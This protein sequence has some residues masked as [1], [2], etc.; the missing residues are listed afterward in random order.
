[1]FKPRVPVS[2]SLN[3]E[4]GGHP[5]VLSVQTPVFCGCRGG[6]S[7]SGVPLTCEASGCSG[8]QCGGWR[9]DFQRETAPRPSFTL[10]SRFPSPCSTGSEVSFSPRSS[11]PFLSLGTQTGVTKMIKGWG[12]RTP[13]G[14]LGNGFFSLERQTL[15]G[16]FVD[17]LELQQVKGKFLNCKSGVTGG[18]HGLRALRGGL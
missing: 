17:V 14:L 5:V 11:C 10:C 2:T 12:N 15:R 4:V 6:G 8:R 9:E 16:V 1:M 3:W 7:E 13:G 18:R